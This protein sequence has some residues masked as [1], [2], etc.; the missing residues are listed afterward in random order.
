[1]REIVTISFDAFCTGNATLADRVEPLEQVVDGLRNQ[2][3][4]NHTLRLQKS[5]CTIEHGFVLS[6]ILTNLERVSDHC[7][8][9]AVCI[10]EMSQHSPLGA[11]D[12]LDHIQ[13]TGKDYQRQFEEY[14]EK[15][16]LA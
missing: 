2:I 8:N 9:V 4:L 1:M 11:H 6:D 10:R 16:K 14:R 12:Y 13:Q 5:E 3:K 7:S 15:Y